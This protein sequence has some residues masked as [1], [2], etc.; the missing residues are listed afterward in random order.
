[1]KIRIIYNPRSGHLARKPGL[2]ALAQRFVAER[3]PDASIVPTERGGHATE[4]ARQAVADGCGVVMAFG[5]DGTMNE[6]A[7]ALVGTDAILAVLPCGSGNGLARHLGIPLAPEAALN[8]LLTG[9]P[10]AID[11]GYAD[12]RAFF[13]TAG[14]G[15]EGE[16]AHRFTRLTQRGL[17]GYIRTSA[18]AWW[19]YVPAEY[20]ITHDGGRV[21]TDAFTL[22]VS[23]CN[24]Y[25]NN[26]YIAPR[27]E[28]DNGFLDLTAVPPVSLLNAAPL[29]L[30]LFRRTLDRRA[31]VPQFRSAKFVVERA[32]P[33]PLQTDGEAH[34]AGAQVEF[35]VRPRS[36]RV[37]VP[38]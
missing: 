38:A 10:R 23:N 20:T 16:I 19:G 22:A 9:R 7:Q 37:L 35:S 15:F 8:L 21:T 25:G 6:V 17:S 12:G 30:A 13:V 26:A 14:L 1:M 33:G 18:Q 32:A 27:A 28:V 3:L 2:L 34:T 24:Q 29:M 36:L 4:L 11:T 31:D 5:G